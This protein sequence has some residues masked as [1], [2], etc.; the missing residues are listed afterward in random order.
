M[1]RVKVNSFPTYAVV[2]GIPHSSDSGSPSECLMSE[3]CFKASTDW[4]FRSCAQEFCNKLRKVRTN[5]TFVW[6]DFLD[7]PCTVFVIILCHGHRADIATI[8]ENS[9]FTIPF[10]NTW[11][12]GQCMTLISLLEYSQNFQKKLH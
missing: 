10:M 9:M 1:G 2:S 12:T 6:N 7:T 11:R 3:E 4:N 8:V 5:S